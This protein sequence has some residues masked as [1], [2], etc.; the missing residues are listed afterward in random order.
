MS[1][2]AKIDKAKWSK[3]HSF[4]F[5]SL[6]LGFFIWGVYATIGPLS[7]FQF[8]TIL[9]FIIPPIATFLGT[10]IIPYI[11]DIRLGRKNS[12]VITMSLYGLGAALI[13]A[14]A[15][16]AKGTWLFTTIM[17]GIF[18]GTLGIEGEVPVGLAYAAE[19]FPLKHREKALTLIPNFNNIGAAVISLIAYLI[20]QFT[21][22]ETIMMASLGIF[23]LIIV[24][25]TL[26]IRKF[27]PDSA[28]W[29]I[30]KGK[31]EEAKK[32]VSSLSEENTRVREN[33]VR[34]GLKTRILFLM[35][36]G[37]SQYLTYGL[38]AYVAPEFYQSQIPGSVAS[39]SIFIA[40]LA[41][42]IAGLGIGLFIVMI[43]SRVFGIL[44]FLGGTITMIPIVLLATGV[45]PF[46][47]ST[48]YILL[49]LNMA[50]SEFAW[51][52]RT[53]MEPLLMPTNARAF[54]IGVVR[55]AP[56]ISYTISGYL[57]TALSWPQWT[58]YNLGLWGLGLAAVGYW[59][60]KGYD[61]NYVP[62]EMTSEEISNLAN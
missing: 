47:L 19:T 10:L 1:I 39:F 18:L 42:G 15:F 6:S 7:Y 62:I 8:K 30:H 16:F 53:I 32:T 36:I 52:T 48:F 35:L 41:A 4:L 61:T 57:T 33:K 38:M 24:G 5:T 50:F 44:S 11:S 14:G 59:F 40:N 46:S 23:T 28:R 56:I 34:V 31:L 20:Y 22:S 43:S 9:V 60:F 21:N 12:Y 17:A 25:I 37:I 27:S 54:L 13:V 55:S 51:A 49:S 2:T 45:L 3:A 58:I 29:Y 26:I